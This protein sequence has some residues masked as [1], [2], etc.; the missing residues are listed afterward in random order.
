MKINRG[1]ATIGE[2]TKGTYFQYDWSGTDT[3]TAGA[4]EAEFEVTLTG[5]IPETYPNDSYIDVL[6]TG[7]IA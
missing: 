1:A 5:S 2:D 3:D 6:I 4:Y 7:D